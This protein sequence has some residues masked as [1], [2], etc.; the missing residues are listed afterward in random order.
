[1]YTDKKTK[2]GKLRLILPTRIGEAVVS[3][4]AGPDLIRTTLEEMKK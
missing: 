4:A 2:G 1:M 3:D